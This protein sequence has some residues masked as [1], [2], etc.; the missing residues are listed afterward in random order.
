MPGRAGRCA[1]RDPVAVGAPRPGR[2]A[3]MPLLDDTRARRPRPGIG[4]RR[5]RRRPA[6][7]RWRLM[8]APPTPPGD[9]LEGRSAPHLTALFKASQCSARRRTRSWSASTTA[10]RR[11]DRVGRLDAGTLVIRLVPGRRARPATLVV[12]RV[13]AIA[14]T[15]NC[16]DF[17]LTLLVPLEDFGKKEQNIYAMRYSVP[18]KS[19]EPSLKVSANGRCGYH[20]ERCR[21][22][23]ARREPVR[24]RSRVRTSNWC[25]PR[26]SWTTRLPP[27]K[28]IRP[29]SFRLPRRSTC[30]APTSAR[31]ATAGC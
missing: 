31:S 11:R 5:S 10:S 1:V 4:R 20:H 2:A 9:V 12:G 17:C 28:P 23:P 26:P 15:G 30:S 24:D 14:E 8:R 6:R 19:Q 29:R 18:E 21:A 25:R 13:K 3:A 27:R 7:R 16:G 22:T